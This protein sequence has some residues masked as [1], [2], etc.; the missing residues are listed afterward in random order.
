MNHLDA[1][2]ARQAAFEPIDFISFLARSAL[3]KAA[4]VIFLSRWE[5]RGG[6]GTR[7]EGGGNHLK[8]SNG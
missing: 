6:G 7:S 2:F 5:K 1:A 4:R 8:K 3:K